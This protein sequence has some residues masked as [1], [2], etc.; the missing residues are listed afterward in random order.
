M[1]RRSPL[2]RTGCQLFFTVGLVFCA[3]Q[4][5]AQPRSVPSVS[6][7]ATPS[8]AP[9][10]APV[11]RAPEFATD[12]EAEKIV[13]AADVSSRVPVGIS[14]IFSPKVQNVYC[15]NQLSATH[16]PAEIRHE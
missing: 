6:T 4:A 1:I 12:I 7:Q 13:F 2:K 8:P 5:M 15:W 11:S 14:D 10:A 9:P 3:S 16:I